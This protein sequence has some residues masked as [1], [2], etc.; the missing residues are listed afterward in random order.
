MTTAPQEMPPV[1]IAF[2]IDNEVLDIL[3]T[4]DRLSAILLSNP[5]IIDVTNNMYENGGTVHLGSTYDPVTQEF[6]AML[7]SVSEVEAAK[8]EA[9][10]AE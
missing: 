1:K 5:L 10:K 6:T 2:V 4:D 8:A 7:P 3:H 9:E